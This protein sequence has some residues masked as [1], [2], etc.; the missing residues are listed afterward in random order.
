MKLLKKNMKRIN[1][2]KIFTI[3]IVFL[4]L[5]TSF[6]SVTAKFNVNNQNK[7]IISNEQTDDFKDIFFDMKISFIMKY[8]NFPSL[9]ACIINDDQV[10]WSKGYGYY[11]INNQKESNDDTIYVIA[12]ITKTIVGTALMQ[13]Y[14]QDY[15]S[16]DE[17][18]NLY[19]PFELR[20]PNFPDEN[21]TFRMLLSHTSSLNINTRNEYYWINFS[22]DPPFSFFPMPYLEETKRRVT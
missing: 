21:I 20:N 5:C 22:G 16:L 13:L 4:F 1:L 19:L 6:I 17:D 7:I 8:A 15:F 14:E 11:D 12:S 2:K 18:V 9:S 10:I 3:F